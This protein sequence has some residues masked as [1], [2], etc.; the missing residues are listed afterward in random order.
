VR[1]DPEPGEGELGHVGA[2]D[3]NETGGAQARHG[4]GVTRG[5]FRVLE[6]A[7]ARRGDVARQVE[8]VLDRDRDAGERRGRGV[9]RAQAIVEIRRRERIRAMNLEKNAF[10]LSAAISDPRQALLDEAAARAAA[11]KLRF[12]LGKRSHGKR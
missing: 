6:R 2:P 9:A 12:E 8:Q 7:R 11:G 4:R 10:P 5:G 3:R 1:I